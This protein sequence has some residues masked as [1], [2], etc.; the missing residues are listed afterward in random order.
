MRSGDA[1][2]CVDPFAG[3]SSAIRSL[4]LEAARVAAS[5]CS[6]LIEGE[7]GTGKK[8]LARWLHDRSERC[9]QP[10][11]DLNC[12]GLS[13]ELLDTELFGHEKGAFTG[14]VSTKDGLFEYA[15]RGT[16]FLDEIGDMDLQIQPKLLKVLEE[17]R[18]R[19]VGG[20]R[21]FQSDV[22]LISATHRNLALQAA[23]EQFRSDLYYRLST[24]VLRVPALRERTEDIPVLCVN[25]LN[26]LTSA[27]KR[28]I[29]RI[30]DEA[31]QQLMNYSW[32][33]NIRE[34][35]NVLEGA[36]I[37]CKD[38]IHAGSLRLAR[39]T[40]HSEPALR[41]K[42]SRESMQTAMR[43]VECLHI[44][45][46]LCETNWNVRSAALTL[47]IPRSSLYQRIKELRIVRQEPVC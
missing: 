30:H 33:G 21:D 35:R 8:V 43:E 9:K 42:P 40:L 34:L 7:T 22:R 28:P 29:P 39:C 37:L 19:H 26:S 16:V 13:R 36:L 44:E 11:V 5:N 23:K 20:L 6:V 12:A 47:G 24:V 38:E 41:P 17:K 4:A 15:N 3:G 2:S 45:N 32:P 18:F 25:L 46:V 10:F 27:L 31:M 14:A 1:R